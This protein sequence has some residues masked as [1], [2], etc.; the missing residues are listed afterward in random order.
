MASATKAFFMD[1]RLWWLTTKSVTK[2]GIGLTQ[3]MVGEKCTQRQKCAPEKE[4][5]EA[6][7]D[8]AAYERTKRCSGQRQEQGAMQWSQEPDPNRQIQNVLD[9]HCD[10]YQ[11][12]QGEPI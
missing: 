6:R 9:W 11:G 8:G 7:S 4:G 5:C 10:E 3:F 2:L 1:W 12:Q